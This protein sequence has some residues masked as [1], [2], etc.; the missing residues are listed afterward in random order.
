MFASEL[1]NMIVPKYFHS[2]IGKYGM[3]LNI[4]ILKLPNRPSTGFATEGYLNIELVS[5]DILLPRSL[6][7][8]VIL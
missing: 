5:S 7:L 1:Q 2:V 8:A 6:V 4:N 3:E